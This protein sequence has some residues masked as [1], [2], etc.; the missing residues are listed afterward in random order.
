MVHCQ[1]LIEKLIETKLIAIPKE[2]RRLCRHDH[3]K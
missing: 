2:Q 3:Y 1:L